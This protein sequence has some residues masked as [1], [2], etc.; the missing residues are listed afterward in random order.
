MKYAEVEKHVKSLREF[1][2]WLEKHGLDLPKFDYD[3]QIKVSGLSY[4]K[5]AMVQAAKVMSKGATINNPLEKNMTTSYY[6]LVRKFGSI[7]FEIWSSRDTVC[8]RKQVGTKIQPKRE[9]VDTGTT[10]EVPVY[11]YDCHPLLAS[12]K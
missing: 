3:L 5:D 2:D 1:A 12:E 11:E 6:E 9:Y 10:E 8:E 4:D 7:N